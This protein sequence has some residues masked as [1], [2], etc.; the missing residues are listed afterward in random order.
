VKLRSALFLLVSGTSLALTAVRFGPSVLPGFDAGPAPTGQWITLPPTANGN[1][2][3]RVCLE[4]TT[5]G[6]TSL[7]PKPS[8]SIG[9]IPIG[10]SPGLRVQEDSTTVCKRHAW[11]CPAGTTCDPAKKPRT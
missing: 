6:I 7:Q 2:W 10:P 8:L 3:Q 5:I 9:G 4:T 1:G 11:R